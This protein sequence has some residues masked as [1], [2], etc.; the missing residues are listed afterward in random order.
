VP[1]QGGIISHPDTAFIYI[2]DWAFLNSYAYVRVSGSA[3]AR[4]VRYSCIFHSR[5]EG[6][7]TQ[8]TRKLDKDDRLRVGTKVRGLNCLVGITI[9]RSVHEI[10]STEEPI[11]ITSRQKDREDQWVLR[12]T[13]FDQ[14]NHPPTPNPFD[15]DPHRSRRPGRSKAIQISK[16]HVGK[17]PYRLSK[18]ILNTLGLNID[19]KAFYNLL[20]KEQANTMSAQEEAQM[21]LYHLESHNVHV[22]VDEQYIVDKEGNK[23]DRI[24]QCIV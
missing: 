22:V 7:R 11:L 1:D 5:K 13:Y 12:Y 3:K 19:R 21:L 23:K 6:E 24:L 10:R 14:H 15:L 17:I 2:N 4:R 9:S 20:R 16:T 8:N 18:G